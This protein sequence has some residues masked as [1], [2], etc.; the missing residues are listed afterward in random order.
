[1][2]RGAR[3]GAIAAAAAIAVAGLA[4]FDAG[5]TPAEAP[6]EVESRPAAPASA[7]TSTSAVERK[8][9]GSTERRSHRRLS[10]VVENVSFSLRKPGPDWVSGPIERRGSGFRNGRLYIS[11]STRGPQGAEGIVFWAGFPHDKRADPC[12]SL[13]SPSASASAAELAQA[14]AAAPGT[15]LV[16]KPSSV[17]VGGRP[18]THVVIAVREHLGCEPGYFYSWEDQMWG[19][20]WPGT[21]VGDTIRVWI[22]DVDGQRLF[23]E[24]ETAPG[25]GLDREV[26]EIVGSI[27][28]DGPDRDS[29]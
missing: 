28:F 27:R 11:N 17:V 24:A 22:V 4:W 15:D 13:L 8:S 9:R 29:R 26:H 12:T 14:V 18:A 19:P 10:R 20:F 16:R 25:S 5:T 7:P 2:T 21:S 23:L 6:T 1:M 3:V